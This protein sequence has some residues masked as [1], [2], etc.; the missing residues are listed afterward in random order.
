MGPTLLAAESLFG[1][2]TDVWVAVSAVGVWFT[3]AVAAFAAGA[4]FLQVSHARKLREE[5]A[6]PY[7]TARL[8]ESDVHWDLAHLVLHN[9][10]QTAAQNVLATITPPL[11]QLV[12]RAGETV[13]EPL[14]RLAV[15]TL[16][17]GQEWDALIE[18]EGMRSRGGEPPKVEPDIHRITVTFD[19]RKGR[20]QPETVSV[21]DMPHWLGRTT[22]VRPDRP[23]S[24]R[25]SPPTCAN[26]G[27]ALRFV[28]KSPMA[29][30]RRGSFSHRMIANCRGGFAGESGS[31][32]D[33]GPPTPC[34]VQHSRRGSD[35]SADGSTLDDRECHRR[36]AGREWEPVP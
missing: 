3:A 7:V 24:W 35:P 10:G 25:R 9:Y 17:P 18:L 34:T 14:D 16:V 15:P 11:R 36:S 28:S 23:D 32:A 1:V 21:V 22:V 27:W 30:P 4:A 12:V 26:C 29:T 33:T 19:N 2:S 31:T 6:A 5:Q 20:P 13:E 8:N